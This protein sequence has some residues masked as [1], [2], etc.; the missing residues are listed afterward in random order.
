MITSVQILEGVTPTKTKNVKN[1]VRFLT[2]FNFDR[3]Y[4]QKRTAQSAKKA[5][6]IRL[7]RQLRALQVFV[8][9]SF[10]H[11]KSEKHFINHISSPIG[12]KKFGE[13]WSTNKK[14]IG[15]HVDPT[16]WS[17]FTGDYNFG[18]YKLLPPQYFTRPTTP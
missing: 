5:P 15:T 3:K 4:L 12:R 13:L 8:I 2:T 10:I 14:V 17:F 1:L 18:P 9:H 11:S 16:K 6:Q 7:V